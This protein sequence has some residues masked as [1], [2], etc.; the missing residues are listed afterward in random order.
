MIGR[1]NAGGAGNGFAAISVTYPVGAVCT[2]SNGSR[3]L[4]AKDTSGKFMFS[5]P[6]NGTWTI[7]AASDV[8]TASKT[9]DVSQY[10]VYS[11]VLDF[12]LVLSE[13]GTDYKPFTAL[14][15]KT[16]S[17][18]QATAT[19]PTVTKNATNV[20]VSL[21]VTKCG[22][23]YCTEK[24]DFSAFT[25]LVA[26]GS[27]YNSTSAIGRLNLRIWSSIGTYANDNVIAD[28]RVA[29]KT[30]ETQLEIPLSDLVAAGTTEGYVGFLIN[31]LE[32]GTS[33]V[34]IDKLWFECK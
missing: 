17:G 6:R 8:Q 13:A 31:T 26:T 22:I 14:A 19:K 4:K 30:T 23:Y 18:A 32:G 1:T 28:G 25:K 9:V 5:V 11:A 27:F 16:S 21:T 20:T 29:G 2:C 3:T 24:I 10:G 33:T 12:E 7:T 15:K 34:R